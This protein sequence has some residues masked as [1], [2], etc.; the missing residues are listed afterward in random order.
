MRPFSICP[1]VGSH[2]PFSGRL[3]MPAPSVCFWTPR[4]SLGHPGSFKS[5]HDLK[6]MRMQTAPLVLRPSLKTTAGFEPGTS[7]CTG[8][9]ATNELYPRRNLY[10]FVTIETIILFINTTNIANPFTS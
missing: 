3:C 6:C 1:P 8:Q 7:I 5:A 4:L 9:R 10:Y 2:I